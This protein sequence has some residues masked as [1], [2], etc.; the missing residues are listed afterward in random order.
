[1]KIV[2]DIIRRQKNLIGGYNGINIEKS[3][4]QFYRSVDR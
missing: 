2:N 1:M 3:E 4:Q